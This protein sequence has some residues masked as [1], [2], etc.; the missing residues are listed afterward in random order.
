MFR[1]V[2]KALISGNS[3]FRAQCC[4]AELSFGML[5]KRADRREDLYHLPGRPPHPGAPEPKVKVSFCL[6]LSRSQ[7]VAWVT[8]L[9]IKLKLYNFFE[10]NWSGKKRMF[11]KKIFMH[12]KKA[13]LKGG[14]SLY[15]DS[16]CVR[17]VLRSIV[18]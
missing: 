3:S 14:F 12:E 11:P 4:N 1:N 17:F 15:I 9:R 7:S 10:D 6:P 8:S 18:I 13:R 5:Q 16:C 2:D